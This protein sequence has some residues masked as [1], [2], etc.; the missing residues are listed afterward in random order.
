LFS[1][2]HLRRYGLDLD[3]NEEPLLEIGQAKMSH[4]DGPLF[5]RIDLIDLS[6]AGHWLLAAQDRKSHRDVLLAQ[7]PAV[8]DCDGESPVLPQ[9]D[10]IYR[11]VGERFLAGPCANRD[12]AGAPGFAGL[13]L[14]R[15]RRARARLGRLTGTLDFAA[16]A[17]D[18]R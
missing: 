12:Q 16:A 11:R 18:G 7:A 13:V 9:L 3:P 17:C 10:H 14:S 1:S 15:D 8:E 4:H 5:T 6:R 2:F